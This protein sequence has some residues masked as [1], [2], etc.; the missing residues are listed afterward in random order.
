MLFRSVTRNDY[1]AGEDLV[2]SAANVV[3]TRTFSKIYAL[4]AL[5]LGWAYCPPDVADV[6]N[7]V[8]GPFNVGSA[9]LAAGVAAIEDNAFVDLARAHNDV[10][11]P[12]LTEQLT[13]LGLEVVPSVGNFLL[14]GFPADAGKD[15][16]AAFDFLRERGIIVRKMG[17][18]GLPSTLRVTV[19]P[20]DETRA[21][22]EALAE[23]VKG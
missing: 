3:M 14:V 10:W 1:G 17:G 9:A 7:R 11:M 6:L 23:F 4:A 18:Y 5:R 21:V 16:N 20:A 13:A 22:A 12:W 8:R 19:G 15:A 2:A